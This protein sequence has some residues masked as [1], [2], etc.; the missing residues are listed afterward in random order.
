MG[1]PFGSL[2]GP[3]W[4]PLKCSFGGMEVGD[5]A[6]LVWFWGNLGVKRNKHERSLPYGPYHTPTNTGHITITA[7]QP[8]KQK[9]VG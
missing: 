7:H 3:F 9:I 2:L 5:R 1:P 6:Y 8:P 4:V